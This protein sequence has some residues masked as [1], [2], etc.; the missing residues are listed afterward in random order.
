LPQRRHRARRATGQAAGN[1]DP[2]LAFIEAIQNGIDRSP[3]GSGLSQSDGLDFRRVLE[4]EHFFVGEGIILSIHQSVDRECPPRAHV[5]LGRLCCARVPA[6]VGA[7]LIDLFFRHERPHSGNVAWRELVPTCSRSSTR[8]WTPRDP[9]A[10]PA[11][12]RPGAADQRQRDRPDVC[13][14]RR[15]T[16]RVASAFERPPAAGPEPRLSTDL[17]KAGDDR[18][19]AAAVLCATNDLTARPRI[20][21]SSHE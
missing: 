16:T 7:G 13:R 12:R 8:C 20:R 6:R 21:E 1:C 14:L 3:G 4:E 2:V 9:G 17:R 19:G 10:V 5:A 11:A 18:C 15:G